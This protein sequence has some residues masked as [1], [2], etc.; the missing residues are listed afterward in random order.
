MSGSIQLT[1]PD[2]SVI[3]ADAGA[4]ARDAVAAIGPGLAKAALAVE[5]DGEIQ[6]LA[7][8]LSRGGAFRVLTDRNE[9]AL[10]VLRHSAAHVMAQAIMEL[11]PDTLLAYGPP[12]EGGFYYDMQLEHRLGPDDFAEIEQRM[13]R[14]IGEDLPFT[15]VVVDREE[16]KRILGDHEYKLD[17]LDKIPEGDEVSFYVTGTDFEGAWRDLCGGPHL[18]STGRIKAF[19]VMKVAGAFWRGDPRLQQLQ[20]VYGTAWFSKKALKQHL[21]RLE[22]AEKR[23][24][25]RI[26]RQ[27]ELF[28]TAGDRTEYHDVEGEQVREDIGP[29]LILWH[30]MGGRL[31]TTVED[32][33]RREHYAAGYEIVYSPHLARSDIW[34]ISGHTGFYRD[35][36]FSG[37]DIDGQ[38]YLI[39]P[40]NCPYHIQIYKSRPRSYRELPLRWAELGTVY[41]YELSGVLEGLKR[42]RGFTQDDAH[43]FCREDQIADEVKGV[44]DFSIRMLATY[45]FEDLAV[46]LST[47]PEKSV[48]DDAGWELA[49]STLREQLERSGLQWK[50]DPGEGVFYG[51]KIDIKIRDVLG[52]E[53][54]CTTIQVDFNLPERFDITYVGTDGKEHRPI[55][56]HRTLLGSMER[57]IGV[58]IEH[59]AGAFPVWLSPVQAVVLPVT[60]RAAEHG[61]GVAA[62]LRAEGFRAE[63]DDRSEKLG[64]K[65]REAQLR[66]IPYMLVVGDREVEDGAVAPRTRKGEDLGAMPKRQF[67]ERLRRTA[68][69]GA[70]EL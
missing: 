23:D 45:G 13:A 61:A 20:R 34:K 53:W 40:M 64:F 39:R 4:P 5:L 51:P 16:A 18:P 25:R 38:E 29:G 37:M 19:K 21:N 17:N 12:V 50:T 9:E 52:R 55:M 7:T 33:W 26:G 56:L 14:I 22:E 41:R 47:R 1:L 35:S 43:L 62:E 8:P 36:M 44:L 15:R 67:I 24:H 27:L 66:K 42:V 32:H 48:G 30:P 31:R 57:F 68:I 49:T 54:Q 6:D 10:D 46:Y 70:E 3:E 65:I 59:F 11:W 58:L 28:S 60:D 2:G 63:L 69:P